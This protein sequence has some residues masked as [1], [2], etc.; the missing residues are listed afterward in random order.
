MAVAVPPPNPAGKV[1]VIVTVPCKIRVTVKGAE[2]DP[3]GIVTEA[4]TLTVSG[5]DDDKAIVVSPACVALIVA[6]N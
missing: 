2:F 5:D 1:A 6:V 3:A 4:G